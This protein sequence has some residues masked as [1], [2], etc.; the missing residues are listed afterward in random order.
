MKQASYRKQMKHAF[1]ILMLLAASASHAEVEP[2]ILNPSGLPVPRY[3]S[4]KYDE[5]NVRVGPGKRYP[6]H[7]VYKRVHLP[8]QIVEEFAHWRKITDYEGSSGWVHKG[9]V[10]GKRSAMIMDKT[11]N[12]YADP[13]ATSRNVLRAAKL[14]IGSLKKCEPD[15]CQLEINKRKGWIRK[16]D[17]WGVG[18]EEVF[19]E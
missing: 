13:D 11:Q 10:D 8:V 12:L 9:A 18:R 5:V 19:K 15:W 2:S 17:I 3:V 7:Y 14:V 6:I 16:A 4:L 1:A